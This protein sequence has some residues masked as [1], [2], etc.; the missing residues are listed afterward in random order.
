M[1]NVLV[2]PLAG[3]SLP[4]W[5]GQAS[6]YTTENI[7]IV[8]EMPRIEAVS[9]ALAAED[10][11]PISRRAT[12]ASESAHEPGQAGKSFDES[13]PTD[14]PFPDPITTAFANPLDSPTSLV[15]QA[16]GTGYSGMG[17]DA[18]L[19]GHGREAGEPTASPQGAATAI[20]WVW[21]GTVPG[22]RS[23]TEA[24]S[25]GW[26]R[27]AATSNQSVLIAPLPSTSP[28]GAETPAAPPLVLFGG[29]GGPQPKAKTPI[30]PADFVPDDQC[31]CTGPGDLDTTT[32]AAN[33]HNA[34]LFS[35]VGVRYA[36]GTV[37][38]VSRDLSSS[39]FG[40][41]WGQTRSWTNG[42]GYAAGFN[43][44]GQVATQQPFLISANSGATIVVVN[45]GTTARYFDLVGSTWVP[46]HYLQDQ[47][48]QNTG[49]HEFV[50]TDTNGDQLHFADFSI[51]LPANEQGKLKSLAD[52]DG[53]TT[54]VTAWTGDGKQQ[55]VQRSTTSG[56]TTVTESYLYA[57]VA[58]GGN[59]GLVQ[60]E[61]L[62][63]QVNGGAWA[64]VRQVQY[65]YYDGVEAHGNLGDLKTVSVQ[66]GAGTTLDTTYY[67]YYTGE[68]GGYVGGLKYVFTPASYA[69]LVAAVGS[70][71]AAAS[72]AAVAPYADNYYEY[73]T[74]QRV[75]KEIAQGAGCSSCSG[76]LGTFTYAYT[77][78]TNAA[79]Y[80][81][82]AMKTV[83]TLPDGNSNTVYTNA[84]GEVMLKV[85]HDVASNLNWDWFNQYDS[86]GRQ[87]LAASPSA[88]TGYDE[89]KA[90][91]LNKVSGNYQ[92]LSDSTGLLQITDYY[93][94]TT[95]TS[96]TAGGVAG[97]R[98]DVKLRQGESGTA[99]LQSGVQYFSR[100]AGGTT[101]YPT[102]TQTV[103]RN[104]DGTGAE[105][106]SY[107]YTWFA[108]TT[109]PQSVAVTKPVIS[110]TQNGPASADVETTFNDV[111]GRPIWFKDADGYLTYTAYDQATGAV[112]KTITDVD[113]TRTSDFTNLPTGWTTPSG[114]GL[115]LITQMVV[116]GLGRTTKL[117]DP[118]GNVTYTV[119]NDVNYERRVYSGW[120]SA[121]GLPTG[122]T[123]R[124]REDRP[125]SYFETLTMTA[126]PHLTG[127][128]PD[129]SEAVANLQTLSR[130]YSNAAGQVVSA[131]AYF[132]L[133]GVTYSTAANLGTEGIN[134]YRTRQD[135][136]DRGRLDRVQ[137][138]TGTINRTVY[139]GLGRVVSIWVGT[140]DTPASGE[141]SPTNNTAP[142]NM[143]DTADYVYDNNTLGGS[144]QV[145]D[146][147]PT[148]V[149]QHPG[150]GAADRVT[151]NYF[152]W[153]DRLVA[154][155]L[156]VQ[157]SEDTTT[158]RP[159]TYTT[160]DNLSE[161][162][163]VQRY[164]GD[165]VTITSSGGVPQAPAASRL[166]AQ[167]ATSFDDQGRTY[168]TRVYSVNPSTGAVSSSALTTNIFYD[169][170]GNV[171]KTAVPG[172]VVT[173]MKYDG[174][175]RPTV[176]YVTDGSGDSTWADASSV[177]NN[178]VLE[179]TETT[180]DA[181]GNAILVTSRQRFHDE[182]ATGA[183]GNPTTTPKAR[184]S[185]A[186]AYYDAANRLTAAVN[187]GTNGGTAWT[188]PATAPAASDTVLTTSYAYSAAGWQDTAT[189]P[190]GLVTKTFYDN[191]GRVT[192]TVEAYDGGAQ[193]ATT[194]KTTEF[195]YDGSNHVVTLQADEP[196]GAFE[197]TK[198]VYGVTTS[199]GSGVNSN[200]LLAAM[201]YPDPTTGLA[202]SSQQET[203]ASNALGERT[204]FTDRNG[205][206]HSYAYDVLGR[207]TA[208][209]VTT[210]GAGVD[211]AVRRLEIAYDVQGN[212]YLFTSYDA[213]SA[214]NVVNQVQRAFNGLGQ[215]ITEYQSHAGVV[216]T[217]TTPKVQ[218]AYVEMAGG[219][220]NSRLT[221]LTYPN[222][223]VL[224]Y[225]YATGTGFAGLDDRI[226]RLSSL[227]DSSATLE[228]YSYLGQG[229][230]VKRGHSQPGVDMTYIALTGE[231]N[232]DAGDKYIGLDRF[233]R[234]V[235]QRW[236]NT[237]TLVATDR[238]Q[239]GYDRDGNR[240][241][242]NNLVNTAFGELYH[243]SGAGNG[244]DNLNQLTG[245]ARG[246]LS[247]SQQ[248]GVLD[249]V[250]SPTATASWNYDGVGNWASVTTNGTT[251]TRG[252]NQ[253]NEITS[254]SGQ[255]TPGYDN[256]GNTITDQTGQTLVYDA[257][258]RLV[259]YKNGGTVLESFQYDA[260][261]RRV[262]ENPGTAKDLYYSA[263][264][265]VL[266]ER[267]SGTV[268]VQQVWS[269]VYV[270]ALVERDRDA[271]GNSA[272]GLEERLYVQQ[273]AN[274]N[275][276]ALINTSGAVGERYVYDPFGAVTYLTATW[277]TLGASAYAWVYGHQGG[278]FDATTGLGYYRLR[279]YS[280][281]LGRW[282]EVDPFSYRAGDVNLYRY[283]ADGPM[284]KLDPLGAEPVL[285]GGA[286]AAA[287]T[288][289]GVAA[290]T[291]A[292][293]GLPVAFIGGAFLFAKNDAA[294]DWFA[295][296]FL[297]KELPV[298][299]RKPWE[300]PPRRKARPPKVEEERDC[301]QQYDDDTARC[302]RIAKEMKLRGYDS[303]TI[304]RWLFACEARASGRKA[305]C[306][307]GE[308]PDTLAPYR[309][310]WD[311]ASS[312]F[313]L[314]LS[315]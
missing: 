241:F 46:H 8:P 304:A 186:A 172:G 287:A 81:S 250:A 29:G 139:E 42:K 94:S 181:D 297:V 220:N 9:L 242:R 104:T 41:G 123:Q 35:G 234:V 289:G 89:T 296:T 303:K 124:Y 305:R 295:R 15:A 276:T 28:S 143:V 202:S 167:S 69:R 277:G 275:V 74:S 13:G 20:P 64:T 135:Y 274:W 18:A 101:I 102:A 17:L 115:H 263:A 246:T 309:A 218:Y 66:D 21:S 67:R 149:I 294:A 127:G 194:N 193:T 19:P 40:I 137:T 161:A 37:R 136:D 82:W 291:A 232:G 280:S 208:D 99:I 52:P 2:N 292:I 226:S 173:K 138:P 272:N 286:G 110:A 231:A 160:Y 251:Q 255:T 103:Y 281:A 284:G 72:D 5:L 258:N 121:T 87:I 312:G 254:I 269:P 302:A 73:D 144:T 146:G 83:E 166:R 279:D 178:Y 260:Q 93:A 270:D 120:N 187:V 158:H 7:R 92:Y 22:D 163:Q 217:S 273:D 197:Q 227:S 298:P 223:R 36:D 48:T 125:G 184:V 39:G 189:D 183:L 201:Q 151:E 239:Y 75:T 152:D 106:T 175:R 47:L 214:G 58:S 91:L 43:G 1:P 59:A 278:R 32:D 204:G 203:Y 130:Q 108:S 256:N 118:N 165:T 10:A 44:N 213:A 176:R 49:Q 235:D 171:L 248:G 266:E 257:W 84:Y 210:L 212:P 285:I 240:L 141:W 51:S 11:A 30:L 211:G 90:D 221:S 26:E 86:Q 85:Y 147:N 261:N 148:Q 238:F 288:G 271:D 24:A 113:T 228:T 169:H 310:P 119:F 300:L 70:N 105:T 27:F 107:A 38:Q 78:S 174:A 307:H 237:T 182:T 126:T 216:N 205:T 264:W 114:G 98:Q 268:K 195:S 170:R 155:K 199:G 60:S 313:P 132:N 164:D 162:V 129:G 61:T 100:T 168:Q 301:Q 290:G 190:R 247:A 63:R 206:V 96:T 245:F 265:Q 188:R 229:T 12:G 262:V 65:A 23:L 109:Q 71:V 314:S 57:Y 207:Q 62:R 244:Y 311:P 283:E 299:V 185:Y 192:K 153:R 198:Y 77:A 55:E 131:D 156:G 157:A 54:T 25:Q 145:G 150:G 282:M 45:N 111:F 252:A 196:G 16:Y 222:G 249:T 191:L 243:V 97:Y 31:S 293:V 14:A 253:Q 76:G 122:P 116:D 230:V 306:E 259:A 133:S 219:A 209:A 128:V 159:I 142:A 140:N 3:A 134:Y 224:N 56:G 180:Y 233:G 117:T 34:S 236:L 315:A 4:D 112:V 6:D 225:T 200:D 53:N 88:V 68:T 215:L 95:A 179:Q 33:P 177:T 267:V 154:S 50:L 80:N 308:D 79:G